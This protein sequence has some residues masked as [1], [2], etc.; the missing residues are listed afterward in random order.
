MASVFKRPSDVA[1]GKLGKW[2][3]SYR[4]QDGKQRTKIGYADKAETLKLAIR[5]ETEAAKLRDGLLDPAEVKRNK[6][7]K[8]PL[9]THLVE[10]GKHLK[11]EG[12]SANY[13]HRVPIA[14]GRLLTLAGFTSI[15]EINAPAIR[16]ALGTMRHDQG[17]GP[18][19]CNFDLSLLKVF[20][21]WLSSH[22]LIEPAIAL[23]I[24]ELKRYKEKV[25]IRRVRRALTSD[26]VDRLL[27]V[28]EA[29]PPVKTSRKD[30]RFEEKWMTGPE[31]TALYRLAL[32][33]GFRVNELRSLR[34]SSFVLTGDDPHVKLAAEFE[35]NGQ[36]TA[37]PITADLAAYL[38][39]FVEGKPADRAPLGIFWDMA[40]F[41][42]R[43]LKLA[44]IPFETGEGVVDFHAL[45]HTFISRLAESGV[46]PKVAQV[47]ARHSSIT[48][49][50]DRYS[51]VNR[52]NLRAAL[53]Q[54]P[55]PKEP[56]R[57]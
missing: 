41:L 13:V 53:D 20:V 56:D 11:D 38:R 44:G 5:L 45:R 2:T 36:G 8:I 34:P 21:K 49:T 4:D 37:Q 16:T 22:R 39:P 27:A 42:R 40:D 18:R 24:S 7:A 9:T 1:R 29:S 57:R 33:T 19:T 52:V 12:D 25:D 28:V 32:G 46:H 6:H 51:H 48:L 35:K 55:A 17:K 31:R 23:E 14:V 30:R 10:F 50:M 3:V 15:G 43:D 26:E 47:L 54:T